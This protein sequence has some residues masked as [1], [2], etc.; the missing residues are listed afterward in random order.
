[1]KPE[2]GHL[3]AVPALG[4]RSSRP[5]Q[6]Q[7]FE[8]I[9]LAQRG[10]ES[11]RLEL[12]RALYPIVA[13]HLSFLLRLPHLREEAIQESMLQIHRSLGRFRIRTSVRAWA[14]KIAT[15]RSGRYL[16]REQRHLSSL[17]ED[18]LVPE[19]A[20]SAGVIEA[21]QE[22]ARL[23]RHLLGLSVK[24]REAFVLVEI[25][26]MTGKE[27]SEVLGVPEDTVFS[28]VRHARREI[29]DLFAQEDARG[30]T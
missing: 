1:L 15:R 29:E 19:R 16:E 8:W 24:K 9:D 28:R 10:D 4:E 2:R 18:G 23:E 7:L 5:T 27:A 21:R 30:R 26:Q 12:L 14:L 11:A 22:L 3:A 6:E 13:K 20:S 17:T 25:L